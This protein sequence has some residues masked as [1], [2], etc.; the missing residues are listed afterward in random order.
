[1]LRIF[2]AFNYFRFMI[3][4]G[5]VMLS[6]IMSKDTNNIAYFAIR[7]LPSSETGISLNIRSG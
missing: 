4:F 7:P 5:K 3:A 1:M 6:V 2:F